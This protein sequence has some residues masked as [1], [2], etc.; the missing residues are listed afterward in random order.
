LKL[1][2]R[3]AF[4]TAGKHSDSHNRTTQSQNNGERPSKK[5]KSNHSDEAELFV[6]PLTR[7][8]T[9]EILLPRFSQFG[10]VDNFY[11]PLDTTTGKP[12]TF[13]FV[14]FQ[15]IG[16]AEAAQTALNETKFKGN[17]VQVTF[18]TRAN[19]AQPAGQHEDFRPI[20][21]SI[22]FMNEAAEE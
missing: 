11:I 7:K 5:S 3:G 8:V 1:V 16:S 18:S 13:G 9:R 20:R 10:K 15:S 6:N 17:K 12:K 2:K 14:K 22:D 4:F 19:P 21:K